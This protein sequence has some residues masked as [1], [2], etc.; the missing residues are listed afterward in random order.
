MNYS[1]GLC[2]FKFHSVIQNRAMCL[3]LN[4]SMSV[5]IAALQ[6]EMD[7]VPMRVHTRLAVLR[8][9]HALKDERKDLIDAMCKIE[10]S[11]FLCLNAT[12]KALL[13][14]RSPL[15][16]LGSIKMIYACDFNSFLLIIYHYIIIKTL[17]EDYTT[18]PPR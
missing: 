14:L 4:V 13:I 10:G 2:V 6:R 8:L 7:W 5:P 9:G 1:A 3:F 16:M 17:F 11:Q 12:D 18:E 15:I